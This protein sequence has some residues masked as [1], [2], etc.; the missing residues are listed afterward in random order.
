MCVKDGDPN[1]DYLDPD[2]VQLFVEDTHQR[3]YDRFPEAFGEVITE[4]FCDEPT[5]Y[6]AQGVSG[7]SASTSVS[8]PHTGFHPKRS[9]P[10][11]GT[12][13]A[14]GLPPPATTCSGSGRGSMPKG[15]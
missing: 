11:C 13:Q 2:A 1:V 6:R 15:S 12:T 4:T 9:T 7:R 14:P 5:L 3:Y 10:P 8:K